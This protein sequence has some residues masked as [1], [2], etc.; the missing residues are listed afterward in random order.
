MM[1]VAFTLSFILAV[2]GAI[3]MFILLVKLNRLMN[4]EYE[5]FLDS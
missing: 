3:V 1:I 2:F 4:L 5:D